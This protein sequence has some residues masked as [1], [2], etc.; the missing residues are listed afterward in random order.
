MGNIR[1]KARNGKDP[2]SVGINPSTGLETAQPVGTGFESW[3]PSITAIYP[4]DPVVFFANLRYIVNVART[5]TLQPSPGTGNVPLT[6]KLDP[7]DGIGGSVGMGFGINERASFSLG[8]EQTHF[9]QSKQG[10]Q[11]ING[12]DFDIGAFTLGFSYRLTESTSVNLG[13]AIGS[14]DGSPDTR[15]LVR[16]PVRLQ[17]F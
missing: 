16:V 2:F 15:I 6:T 13:F 14:T 11:A 10:G 7:G 3:E 9:K 17:V 5:V 1:Y 4:S 8:Y 12:S